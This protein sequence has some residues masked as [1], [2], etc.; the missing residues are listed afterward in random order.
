MLHVGG[1][2]FVSIM[3]MRYTLPALGWDTRRRG[4]PQTAYRLLLNLEYLLGAPGVGRS[5]TTCAP[6]ACAL[7][8]AL[9]SVMPVPEICAPPHA[10]E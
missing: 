7:V 2:M 5:L 6:L 10:H 3:F 9:V 4:D 1:G 8:N